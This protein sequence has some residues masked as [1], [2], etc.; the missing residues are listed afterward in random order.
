MRQLNVT[1]PMPALRP[2][3]RQLQ[4]PRLRQVAGRGRPMASSGMT[5]I[6]VMVA[7][8]IAG[9]L[10]GVGL[11]FMGDAL[12][13]ARLREAGNTLLAETHF[14]RSEA[15]KR[16]ARVRLLADGASVR[17]LDL[18]Q[19]EPGVEIRQ[20]TLAN[21]TQVA[22][23]ARIDFGSDGRPVPFGTSVAVNMAA[24]GSTCTSERRCPGLRVD[25]GGA[26]RL[27][28]DRLVCP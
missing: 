11:P 24:A 10:V 3:A 9:V 14:A 8:V 26:I 19:D 1:A 16:N 20:V 18:S 5:L 28:G 2:Q 21:P 25:A 23:P 17:V 15:I 13:N 7:L 27:C 22:A 6:E 4:P 12:A